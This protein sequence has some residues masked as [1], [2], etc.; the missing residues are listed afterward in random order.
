MITYLLA[1][2]SDSMW[3]VAGESLRLARD[4]GYLCET[5]FP[6]AQTAEHVTRQYAT[7]RLPA[8]L[9]YRRQMVLATKC[10]SSLL[11]V[12]FNHDI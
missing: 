9:Q 4:F 6:A 10:V 2:V 7:T 3:L 5:E 8:E 12:W 11:T 1:T